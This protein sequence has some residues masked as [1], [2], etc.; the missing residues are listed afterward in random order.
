MPRERAVAGIAAKR[1]VS[2][3]RSVALVKSTAT[4]DTSADCITPPWYRLERTGADSVPRY[5]Q[6]HNRLLP[7]SINMGPGFAA[8][9]TFDFT[10]PVAA[11]T[12]VHDTAT[13][14]AIP[15]SALAERLAAAGAGP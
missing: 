14:I 12:S 3:N 9:M 6:M 15:V 5:Q 11:G 13:G 1:L 2:A 7:M 10:T 4:L 8:K